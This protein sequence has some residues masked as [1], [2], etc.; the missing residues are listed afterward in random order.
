V[1]A[2]RLCILAGD[3][4]WGVGARFIAPAR[5]GAVPIITSKDA[6]PAWK[7]KFFVALKEMEKIGNDRSEE[8]VNS[9]VIYY[10]QYCRIS[11]LFREEKDA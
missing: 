7:A 10:R 2:L 11:P 3:Y 4:E 8:S 5:G 1:K 6:E 9:K